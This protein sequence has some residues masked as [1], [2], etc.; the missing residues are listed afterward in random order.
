M[1]DQTSLWIDVGEPNPER[2]KKSTRLA[3]H[4]KIYS[5]N[6]KSDVWW[7]QGQGKFGLYNADIIR[8]NHSQIDE[9][10]QMLSRTM[11]LSVTITGQSAFIAGD[12]NEVDLHWEVLQEKK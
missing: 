8:F 5:F 10:T 1:D 12:N 11:D 9:L 4:V 7:Q 3:Q 6:S 2:L